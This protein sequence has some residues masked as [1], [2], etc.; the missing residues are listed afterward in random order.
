MGKHMNIDDRLSIQSYL[1]DG[2]SFAE[3]ARELGRDKA[4]ISRE[5]KK[6]RC[7]ITYKDTFTLQ[8]HNACVKRF[9]C[10]IK[11]KCKSPACYKQYH[12]SCKLCGCCN[13]YCS[14][15]EE[16]ICEQYDKPPYVCNGCKK[17]PRCPLSKWVYEAKTAQQKYEETLSESRQGICLNDDELIELDSII[18]PLLKKGHSVRNIC[19]N[20]NEII[21]VSDK[22]IY[23]YLRDHRLSTDIFDLRR[24]IQRKP[25][26]KPG[27]PLLVDKKCREGRTYSD[28]QM[29]M[30]ENPDTNVVEMDTVEGN[31]GGKVI[32][33]LFFRNCNLQLGFLREKNTAASV[34]DIFLALRSRLTSDEFTKLFPVILADRG[35]EFSSPL[36]IEMD[37]ETGELQTRLFYCDPGMPSQKGGCERNHEMI[38]YILPK[39]TS[40]DLLTQEDVSLIM[41]HINS[42]RREMYNHKSPAELFQTIYGTTIAKKLGVELVSS[43]NISLTPELIH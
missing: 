9:D 42:Y 30:K 13:P 34:K 20:N 21:S 40:F 6:Y 23:R 3:I 28:F 32:L 37:Y 26:R 43:H 17:K 38:R 31:R 1:K 11:D 39:G 2:L 33:T 14:D 8:T 18:S 27:P 10:A 35:T 22:T 7:Y 19:Q 16:E 29:F 4:T 15:F 36:D 25:R 12:K 41:N 5:V 24:T